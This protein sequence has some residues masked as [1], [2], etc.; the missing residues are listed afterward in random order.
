MISWMYPSHVA[1]ATFHDRQGNDSRDQ[2]DLY[3]YF[4]GWTSIRN[5]CLLH[6]SYDLLDL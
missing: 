5:I 1:S 3:A 2:G 6:L 4:I